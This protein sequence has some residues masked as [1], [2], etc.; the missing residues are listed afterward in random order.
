MED[1]IGIQAVR[2]VLQAEPERARCLYV[3]R[4]RR[5]GRVSELIALAKAAGVRFSSVEPAFFK[6]RVEEG[7]HQGVLLEAQG[8]ITHDET[9]LLAHLQEIDTPL[10]LV[11][12][13]ITDPRNLG[14]CLRSASAAGVDAVVLPRRQ[15]APLNSLALKTAQGGAEALFIAEVSNLARTLEAL[16]ARNIWLVG[17]AGEAEQN[18][19]QVDMQGSLAIVLGSEGKGLRRLT[20]EACDFLAAIPMQGVVTSLNVSVACGVLLFEALRQRRK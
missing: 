9:A 5:D 18:Y 6:R 19:D 3:Q 1:V 20:R 10:L 15:T 14:A 2:A 13:G 17:A 12:D 8:L 16:K 11:L 4:G 7:A